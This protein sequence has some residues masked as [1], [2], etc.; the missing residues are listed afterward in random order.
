M[1]NLLDEDLITM[2]SPLTLFLQPQY[3]P[4]CSHGLYCCGRIQYLYRD[5][6]ATSLLDA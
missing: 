2:K 6:C 1:Y 4:V 5:V 3:F